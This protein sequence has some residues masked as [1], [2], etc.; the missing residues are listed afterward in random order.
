MRD[1]ALRLAVV[2]RRW[3]REVGL[4][5]QVKELGSLEELFR[6]CVSLNEGDLIAGLVIGGIDHAGMERVFNFSFKSGTSQLPG[7]D[8]WR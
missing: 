6:A 3:D 2:L 7:G 5:E 8:C 4:S 1:R